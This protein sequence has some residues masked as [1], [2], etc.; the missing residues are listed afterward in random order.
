MT[1]LGEISM[2]GA[3]AYTEKEFETCI[4]LIA[5]KKLN[6]KKYIDEIVPLE[7]AQDSFLKL[8]SGKNSEVKIIFHP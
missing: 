8:T 1:V 7:K 5:A 4:E 3:I 2:V 6:V